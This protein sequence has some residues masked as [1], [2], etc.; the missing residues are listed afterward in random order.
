MKIYLITYKP[1]DNKG[2]IY[3]RQL[4]QV[5]TNEEEAKKEML[6]AMECFNKTRCAWQIEEKDLRD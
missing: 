3:N 4:Y 2:K 1:V 6:K 5:L